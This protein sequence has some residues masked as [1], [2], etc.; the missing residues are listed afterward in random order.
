MGLFI[1]NSIKVT[2]FRVSQCR[3][4]AELVIGVVKPA[5]SDNLRITSG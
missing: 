4:F 5:W 1:K 3:V 2:Y